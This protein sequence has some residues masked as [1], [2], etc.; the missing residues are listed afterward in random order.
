VRCA[1]VCVHRPSLR[2]RGL[3]ESDLVPGCRVVDEAEA[4]AVLGGGRRDIGTLR[5]LGI[6]T[7]RVV[8]LRSGPWM[9]A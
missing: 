5:F 4:A 3:S 2:A 9:N 8:V 7:N 6:P 1:V